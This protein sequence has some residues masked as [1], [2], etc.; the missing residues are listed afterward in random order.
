MNNPFKS[1]T[2]MLTCKLLTRLARTAENDS[3]QKSLPMLTED[4]TIA[5]FPRSLKT[6]HGAPLGRLTWHDVTWRDMAAQWSDGDALTL[7]RRRSDGA[8]VLRRRSDGDAL[9]VWQS[10]GDNKD[11]AAENIVHVRNA[12]KDQAAERQVHV[13]LPAKIKQRSVKFM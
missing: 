5:E 12:N 2:P 1:L 13:G 3:E 6:E 10:D 11:Q 4:K 8:A 9:T 7:W